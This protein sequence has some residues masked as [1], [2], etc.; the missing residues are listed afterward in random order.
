MDIKEKT[1]QMLNR[2]TTGNN[3]AKGRIVLAEDLVLSANIT[4]NDNLICIKGRVISQNL[5][6]EY[7]TS[8][9]IDTENKRILSTFCSCMD[10]EKHEFTKRN[11]C[12]KHLNATFFKVFEEL[13]MHPMLQDKEELEEGAPGG[14]FREKSLLC[15]LIG[16]DKEK[17]EIRIDVYVNRTGIRDN[18]SAEFRIGNKTNKSSGLYIM[19][20]INYFL[21]AVRNRIP[22]SYSKNFTFSSERHKLSVKDRNLVDFI[23]TLKEIK[24]GL[25]YD[26]RTGDKAVDGKYLNI[27]KFMVRDFFKVIKN[28][29]IFLNEGFFYKPVETEVVMGPP[30]IDFDLKLV[31]DNFA[32]KSAGGMPVTLGSRND[33]FLYGSLIYIP[34][35]E[36]CYRIAPYMKA[37][38]TMKVINISA[39]EEERVLRRLIP[40]LA[41]LAQE[42]I[43]SKTIQDKIVMAVCFFKFYFD[44]KGRDIILKLNVRYGMYEFNILHDCDEKVVYRDMKKEEEVAGLVRSFGFEEIGD[45]FYLKSGDERAFEFFKYE[46]GRLQ[47]VGDVFYSEGFKG[48]KNINP[49]TFRGEIKPGSF[50]YFEFEFKIGDIPKEET[51]AILRAFRDNVKYHKLKTGEFIDLE[52]LE[53][54]NFLKLLDAVSSKGLDGNKAQINK[55]R[56]AYL[57][58]YIEEN[59]IRYISG[60]GELEKIKDKLKNIDKLEFDI[61]DEFNGVLREYQKIGFNWLKVLDYLGFGGILGD[62]MGLGKTIQAIAFILSNKGSKTLIVAPT[63]LTYNWINEFEKFAPNLRVAAFN[64]LKDERSDKIQNI[65]DYDVAITTYNLLRRDLDSYKEVR[66]DYCLLDEAQFIKNPHSQSA[67]A[68]K[69]I[70]A[71][72]RYAL[73]GTPMENSL[74]ELWSIFDF[75]MPGYLYDEKKFGT[76]YNNK[77][78]DTPE[79]L[80]ELNKLIKPFI[81]R[82]KKK[83]VIK[84][85]PD[86][87]EKILVVNFDE[88]Q[89]KIY[90]AYADHAVQVLEKKVRNDEFKRSKIEILSYITKLRQLCLDPSIIVNEYSGGSAKMDAVIE[91]L[92]Q[93]VEENHRV[94]V[95]SQFTSVLKNIGGRLTNDGL[96]YSYLD[97]SIPSEKRMQMVE[98]FNSGENSVFLISLKAGGTGLNL[99]S[100]D[101][102][103]HFDPWWNP[104]V[105]DQAT[106][107][108]HRIGQENIVEVIKIIAK[109]TIEEKILQLQEN[110]RRL[111][112]EV[113][114]EELKSAEKFSALSEEDIMSL[115]Y[116]R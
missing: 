4:E 50:N 71:V 86:K 53:M 24:G 35:Q 63:S 64:G 85:L 116:D 76:R 110:K 39:K 115:F 107:R 36:F 109:G 80:D 99:T 42:L 84:E 21:A 1:M 54:N 38:K 104:A 113:M 89:K 74:M 31:K 15:T 106:D 55:A 88:E 61:P 12:C 92:S 41:S 81:L 102:V 11:Y 10:F 25:G 7:K 95:F 5:Y 30:A 62:E 19:R 83:D 90:K 45:L 6:N 60:T 32:L 98:A 58:D 73:T 67:E 114:G 22:I 72:G 87:I 2:G 78:K 14:I 51:A 52:E 13:S 103:I 40:D 100:A 108:A 34:E 96:S 70:N 97:G 9:E 47:E 93:S 29:R 16:D 46:I 111:I 68:V 33:I 23:E 66:F 65:D 18:I 57:Q 94:L 49:S 44:K 112:S 105:E 3:Q 69:E 101:I 91:L 27:P 26:S 77:L 48:I 56:A 37:F 82:R 43:L 79:I 28:H 59:S 8:I 20:D 17:E 75:I